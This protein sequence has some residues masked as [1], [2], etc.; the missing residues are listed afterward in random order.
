MGGDQP[1]RKVV[2]SQKFGGCVKVVAVSGFDLYVELSD[3]R[4]KTAPE[5]EL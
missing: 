1:S 5:I 3:K 4:A 2:A